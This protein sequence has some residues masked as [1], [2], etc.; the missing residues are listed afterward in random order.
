M[1]GRHPRGHWNEVMD[2]VRL[3]Y[4][5]GHFTTAQVAELM[6]AYVNP[7]EAAR[8][9]DQLRSYKRHEV[10]ESR[11]KDAVSVGLRSMAAQLLWNRAQSGAVVRVGEATFRF[12]RKGD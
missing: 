1:S 8:R 7:M 10:Y 2:R 12:A 9:S 5:A 11:M 4:G 3:E 6:R